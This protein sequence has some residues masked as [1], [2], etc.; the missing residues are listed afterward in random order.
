MKPIKVLYIR[1]SFDPGGTESLLVNL[2]NY[3]QD[4][5]QFIYCLLK[6]GILI[7]AL[8]NDKNQYI[9]LFRKSTI[10][11]QIIHRLRTLIKDEHIH[12]I[13]THQFIEL[14]YGIVLKILCPK[15]KLY[16][17]IHS[18]SFKSKVFKLLEKF[19]IK[20]TDVTFTVSFAAKNYLI[21]EGFER[22]KITVLYNAISSP[23]RLVLPDSINKL[24]ARD[25]D[26]FFI[27]MVGNF[28]QAKDQ[29]TLC[30]AFNLV[31]D[32]FPFLSLV[33][34]GD[35]LENGQKCRDALREEFINRRVFFLGVVSPASSYLH[36]FDLMVF[37]SLSE[38]FGMV[39]IEA[40]LS[41]LP[42]LASDIPVM[43]E[44]S[45]RGKYFS[46]FRA[47]D[48]EDLALKLREVLISRRSFKTE[49]VSDHDLYL[50]YFRSRFSFSDYFNQ[51]LLYYNS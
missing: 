17:T 8:R 25:V 1:S 35:E 18:L 20:F 51:L 37:S 23:T 4:D 48:F 49:L 34:I 14:F 39:V 26:R 24:F 13:H 36:Y 7:D 32:D 11:I 28:T 6:R 50:N 47:G 2:Y 27:V 16:H 29:L 44:L 21:S 45:E 9:E 3:N 31:A 43:Q 22:E 41:D 42:V 40:I 46:L 19:F 10:D 33:F 5:I 15:I 30:K 12:I 38:T